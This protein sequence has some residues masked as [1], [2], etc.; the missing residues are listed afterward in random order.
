MKELRKIEDK[1]TKLSEV[2]ESELEAELKAL[3]AEEEELDKR[4]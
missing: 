2:S 1:L 4:L 3:E